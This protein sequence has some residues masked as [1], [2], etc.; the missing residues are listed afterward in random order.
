VPNLVGQALDLGRDFALV[1]PE[2]MRMIRS[3]FRDQS[4][5]SFGSRRAAVDHTTN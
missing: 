3:C 5:S 1:W 4:D 2:P